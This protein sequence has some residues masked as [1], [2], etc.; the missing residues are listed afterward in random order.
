MSMI[1]F[2]VINY[3]QLISIEVLQ[4]LNYLFKCV[5][6]DF[7]SS[8]SFAAAGDIWLRVAFLFHIYYIYGHFF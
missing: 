6:R 8:T 5:T 3:M 4:I 7:C 1:L 2:R